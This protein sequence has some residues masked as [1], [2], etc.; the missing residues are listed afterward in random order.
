MN[1][2][3]PTAKE[4]QSTMDLIAAEEAKNRF[5]Q[6]L[7]SLRTLRENEAIAEGDLWKTRNGPMSWSI[8]TR[9]WQ[10]KSPLDW[11]CKN[12]VIYTT[13]L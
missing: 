6:R 4:I 8:C 7:D 11:R 2:R 5:P 13:R 3:T 10:G 9:D 1:P 12:L